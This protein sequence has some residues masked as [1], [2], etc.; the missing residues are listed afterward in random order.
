[1]AILFMYNYIK[2]RQFM[3]LSIKNILS[4]GKFDKN[5]NYSISFYEK[6]KV[7]FDSKN[8]CQVEKKK[9]GLGQRTNLEC[10]Y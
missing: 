4:Q 9:S 3:F 8:K 1:M 7:E 2:T 5:I 10:Q 6:F